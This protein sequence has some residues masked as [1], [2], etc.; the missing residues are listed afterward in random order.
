ME[1]GA[2]M[3]LKVGAKLGVYEVLAPAGAGGMGEVYR[4]R[5]PELQRDVAIKLLPASFANDPDRLRR[6]QQEARVAAALTH[7]NI[8]QIFDV[9]AQNGTPYIVTEFLEGETL[10]DRLR[11]GALSLR[12]AIEYGIQ[13][14]H[15]L[16]AA[17]AKN[18]VHR[19]LKP[20]NIFLTS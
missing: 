7:P 17:H 11:H 2:R 16:A 14:A 4:A 5:H 1:R 12:K 10:R 20:D 18:I 15:A 8:L 9:G 19:D 3:G 6:F 13:I